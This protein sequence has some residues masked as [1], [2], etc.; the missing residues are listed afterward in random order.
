MEKFNV[1][2]QPGSILG[3]LRSIGYNLKTALSDIIDN[4]IAAEAKKIEIINNDLEK[5]NGKL[6]WLTIIDDGFG[7]SKDDMLKALTLGGDGIEYERSPE[8]LGRFGLGLKTASLSQC[9]R[10][11]LISKN[12]DNLINSLIFDLDHIATNGWE[13]YTLDDNSDILKKITQRTEDK[14]IFENDSWTAVHWEKL[15]K[16]K[17]SSISNFYSELTKV[18]NHFELIYHKFKGKVNIRLNGTLVDYWN[19]YQTAISSQEKHFKY[20]NS[21]DTYSVKGH[22]LKHSSEFKNTQ[23]YENQ[24]LIGTFNQNQGFFVYRNNRLIY[25]GSWLGLFNKEHHYILARIEIN[26]NNKLESDLAWG[27][28]ISKS[29]VSIPKYAEADIRSECNRV[30]SEANNTFR[31]HGGVRKHIIRTKN[32]ETEIQPIWSFESKGTKNGEKNQYKINTKHPLF[33]NFQKKIERNSDAKRDFKE[34]LKYIE[35]YLPIDN[36]FARKASNEVEQSSI[37]EDDVFESF[38]ELLNDYS[39]KMDINKAFTKLIRIEPYNSLSFDQAKME[40]LGV[41]YNKIQL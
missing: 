28:N 11:I 27:V 10:L 25:R 5:T 36:I 35:N 13:V 12:Q 22:V 21:D 20:N 3:S 30:R 17:I 19:P 38:K 8:D 15:D 7:M 39:V 2:P 1:K 9:R 40:T 4:S 23:E 14:S 34:I 31:F 6:D 33:E 41:D 16:I 26:L 37:E 24:S 18:R 29:S 32:K